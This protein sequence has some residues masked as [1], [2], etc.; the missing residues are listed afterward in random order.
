MSKEF[1][2]NL[3]KGVFTLSLDFE[4]IWGT[5]DLGLENFKKLCLIERETVIDRLLELFEKYKFPATWA[6]LGHL[7]LD[8]C[9][10]NHPEIARSEFAWL[11]EDWFA[12]DPGG[13]EDENSIHLGKSLVEKIQNCAV[14]QEIGSH[15]FSHIVF[16]DAGCSPETAESEIAECVRIAE[17]QGV[18]LNSFVFPRNEIGYLEV[19][20]K[21]GFTNFRG[22]EPNWYE[23]RRVPEAVRRGLRLV[24]VLRAAT[25]PTVLPEMTKAGLWNIAG[26]AMFFP[27]HGFRRHIPMNLRVKRAVKGL[28]LAAKRREIFHLWFHPTNLT[29]NLE[30]MFE[31]LEK[32]LIHA[33]NLREKGDLEF[34]TMEQISERFTK[35]FHD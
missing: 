23:N 2:N 9:E 27:M 7:F 12:H 6:V 13:I 33:A 20:K 22:V 10:A 35:L 8:K 5:A 15:S 28:N 25:P 1:S 18:K 32:I 11:K 31:G 14:P 4:L 34:L 3:D 21:F 26:S 29:D 30:T 24:D 17:A 16:G 19:L